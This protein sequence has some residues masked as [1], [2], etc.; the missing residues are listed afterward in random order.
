MKQQGA[1]IRVASAV[2]TQGGTIEVDVGTNDTT[3]QVSTGGL[4]EVTLVPVPP[5]KHVSI[6][7]PAVTPGTLVVVSVGTGLR[8]HCCVLEVVSTGP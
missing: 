8:R 7:V 3:V 6:P 1:G 2:V 4:G 5:G